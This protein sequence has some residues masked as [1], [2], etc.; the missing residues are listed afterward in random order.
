MMYIRGFAAVCKTGGRNEARGRRRRK[1]R[2]RLRM[3]RTRRRDGG[4]REEGSVVR[5]ERE[6]RRE[7]GEEEDEEEEIST[8]SLMGPRVPLA[9]DT[10]KREAWYLVSI[11]S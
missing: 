11:K 5:E 4:K 8:Y 9:S 7:Q 2:K 6:A 10:V 1:R 3:R